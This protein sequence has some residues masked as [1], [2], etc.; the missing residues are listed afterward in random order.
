M[1]SGDVSTPSAAHR[2]FRDAPVEEHKE[3]AIPPSA[4]LAQ[5]EHRPVE[6][7]EP[8]TTVQYWSD[9]NH[10]YFSSHSL[11]VLA[12][13]PDSGEAESILGWTQS[14]EEFSRVFAVCPG[15]VY[16]MAIRFLI[17]ATGEGDRRER[18]PVFGRGM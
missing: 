15:R 10:T 11:H 12:D 8:P 17:R 5:L 9:F 6:E 16:P 18:P 13:L 4:Y 1:V 2:T 7:I 3:E 14:K